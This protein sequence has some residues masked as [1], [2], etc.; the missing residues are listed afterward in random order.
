MQPKTATASPRSVNTLAP[1]ATSALLA[2]VL[3]ILTLEGCS[4]SNDS[5]SAIATGAQALTFTHT[6]FDAQPTRRGP[7]AQPPTYAT[8]NPP[9]LPAA[10][11]ISTG[12]TLSPPGVVQTRLHS[13]FMRSPVD[14]WA[15]GTRI[16]HYDGHRWHDALPDMINQ[17]DIFMLSATSGWAVGDDSVLRFTHG[18]WSQLDDPIIDA[19][20]MDG[21]LG[22]NKVQFVSET[23]GWA[24]GTVGI[25]Q[26]KDGSW[27]QVGAPALAPLYGLY[28][29]SSSDGWA[30][31]ALGTILHYTMGKWQV[32]DNPASKTS[33]AA[34]RSIY[35]TS[36]T[37]GWAVGGSDVLHYTFGHWIKVTMPSDANPFAV[38]MVSAREGWAVGNAVYHYQDGSWQREGIRVDEP[39]SGIYITD[40]GEGWAVGGGTILHYQHGIWSIYITQN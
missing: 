1:T 34:L 38:F 6:P 18:R 9:A 15:T 29:I 16:A 13:V 23:E 10:P 39:L 17:N 5:A 21:N 25:L 35:M 3:L 30:V 4:N 12:Q 2:L 27:S 19:L 8:S 32:V 11:T 31:G 14:C 28:M 36:S 22:L 20:A 40:T 24:V 37:D 26:Y 7:S 33:S